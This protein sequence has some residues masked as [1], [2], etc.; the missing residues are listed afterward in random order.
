MGGRNNLYWLQGFSGHG[1]LPTLASARVVADAILG[2]DADLQVFQRI[3]AYDF[4][5]GRH[6]AAPLEAVGKAYY[7][8][9]DAF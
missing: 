8:L 7:R 9:R 2:D 5:G 3:K 6:L 1:V 4:P